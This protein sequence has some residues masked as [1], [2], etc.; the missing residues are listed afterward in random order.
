MD[1][2]PLA[3]AGDTRGIWLAVQNARSMNDLR[4]AVAASEGRLFVNKR[5]RAVQLR[6][7]G[8]SDAI[9]ASLPLSDTQIASFSD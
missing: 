8:G 9:V 2:D 5:R 6:A 1:A 3:S 4:V 7:C